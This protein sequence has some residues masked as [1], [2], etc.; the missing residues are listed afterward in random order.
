MKIQPLDHRSVNSISSSIAPSS[1]DVDW[2]STKLRQSNSSSLPHATDLEMTVVREVLAAG[3][4]RQHFNNSIQKVVNTRD[5][6]DL[7]DVSRS[8]SDYY[9]HTMLT[10]K[11]IAKGV[12]S[13][14][15]LTNLQ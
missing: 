3:R 8:M 7:L 10:T 2:F 13:V 5:P 9:T 11:I 15:K 6:L 14:E 4:H 1:A 12:Q